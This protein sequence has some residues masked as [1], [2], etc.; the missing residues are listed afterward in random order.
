ML[1]SRPLEYE[2][3]SGEHTILSLVDNLR[4][5]HST[6]IALGE[7]P[8]QHNSIASFFWK[9]YDCEEENRKLHGTTARFSIHLGP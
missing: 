5:I 7:A 4:R 2:M 8:R 1:V 9:K 6:M 3:R